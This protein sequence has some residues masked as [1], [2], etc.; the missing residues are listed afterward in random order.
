MTWFFGKRNSIIVVLVLAI[1]LGTGIRFFDLTDLPLDFAPTRQL[2]SAL[3]ARG[4]YYA[5]LPANAPLPQGSS[6]AA[7]WQR[8]VAI[9]QWESSQVI[10]PEVIETITALTYRLVGEHLWIARVYSSLFWV[11]AG[12][13]L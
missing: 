5:I 9:Q 1:L 12:V 7:P 4:M 13:A 10:E 6:A 3:K 2:F 8:A 11:L